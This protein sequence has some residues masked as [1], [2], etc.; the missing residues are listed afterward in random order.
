[1]EYIS[2]E[3]VANVSPRFLKEKFE[4]NNNNSTYS[5]RVLE[6]GESKCFGLLFFDTKIVLFYVL[7][8]NILTQKKSVHFSLKGPKQRGKGS[9]L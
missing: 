1:M 7:L 3:R 4:N 2:L 5:E 6:G 8:D 9:S